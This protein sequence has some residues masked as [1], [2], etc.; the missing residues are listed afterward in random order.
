ML[1][2]NLH[3]KMQH[4]VQGDSLTLKYW[5]NAP[6]G[7]TLGLL[8]L[9]WCQCDH[10]LIVAFLLEESLNEPALYQKQTLK[11]GWKC[12]CLHW[13]SNQ[14]KWLLKGSPALVSKTTTPDSYINVWV[15]SGEGVI[16]YRLPLD[17]PL[18]LI[19]S[20]QN[21]WILSRIVF[22]DTYTI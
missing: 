14:S 5:F 8:A 20:V 15:Y 22:F 9:L 13:K 18:G 12:M 3:Y 2:Y 7:A 16:H 19:F 11:F 21:V 10:D 4:L 17:Y 1:F 6:M